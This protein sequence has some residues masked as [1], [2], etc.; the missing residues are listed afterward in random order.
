MKQLALDLAQSPPPTLE[1]FVGGRNAELIQNLKKLAAREAGERFIY[2]WGERGSGRS[3]LLQGVAA[4]ARAAKASA[5]YIA[6]TRDTRFAEGVE[7]P[8]CVAVDDVDILGDDAQVALFHLYNAL[9]E[10]RGSL[11]ASGDAPPVQLKL[12]RDLV[13]R[14]GWG[15]VYQVRAL[16]DE[17]KAQALTRHAAAR[18]FPIP[19][20]VCDYLLARVR[21]DMPSLLATLD[22]LDR[23]S[24]E[25]KRPITVALAREL[26]QT[27]KEQES[28]TG[29][30]D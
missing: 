30:E 21:R 25:A 15:L 18:G 2:I 7:S 11:V 17:E 14:L 26:L 4:A 29:I 9:R 22:A 28:G 6:C 24:L 8:D 10:R 12:R 13:T 16:S 20:E 27:A 1:N 5:A 3:H 23:H 19:D